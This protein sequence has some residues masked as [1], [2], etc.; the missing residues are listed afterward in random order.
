MPPESTIS[1][2]QGLRIWPLAGP[3]KPIKDSS[4]KHQ[5]TV[6]CHIVQADSQGRSISSVCHIFLQSYKISK[7]FL[8]CSENGV[9]QAEMEASH[10]EANLAT[11]LHFFT[12]LQQI[13]SP[14][15]FLYSEFLVK[16]KAS[17]LPLHFL[18][19][20]QETINL[21]ILFYAEFLVKWIA[22]STAPPL[23][24]LSTADPQPSHLSLLRVLSQVKSLSTAPPLLILS[25]ED[26]RPSHPSLLRVL[27]QVKNL[28]TAPSL[29]ILSTEDN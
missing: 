27:S 10:H 28:S 17:A 7:R 16:W 13:L 3:Q 14:L 21:L 12:F 25:T 19:F 9:T 29:L 1:P 15:I 23:L 4:T 20:L 18:S 22:P 11:A 6:S 24:I 26:N 8:C 2:S 5:Q